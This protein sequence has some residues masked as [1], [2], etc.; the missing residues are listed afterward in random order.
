MLLFALMVELN[1]VDGYSKSPQDE[2]FLLQHHPVSVGGHAMIIDACELTN[3]ALNSV[4]HCYDFVLW[5]SQ[6]R[7]SI[8]D[9]SWTL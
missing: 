9:V 2:K 3:R 5:I 6:Q 7:R 4:L 8:Q 1:F